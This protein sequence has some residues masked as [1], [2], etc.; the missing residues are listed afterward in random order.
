MEKWILCGT[1]VGQHC[2][3]SKTD[4]PPGL[5]CTL[6]CWLWLL[7]E[8]DC[9]DGLNWN[10]SPQ[11]DWPGEI[12]AVLIGWGRVD[13]FSKWTN[14]RQKLS[15]KTKRGR[16]KGQKKKKHT[17]TVWDNREEETEK[18]RNLCQKGE[19]VFDILAS[20]TEATKLDLSVRSP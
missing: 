8:S 2:L 5:S 4:R 1:K 13:I 11:S 17:E 7:R 15:K 14:S 19:K 9:F 20:F 12:L 16:N 10:V 18:K 3:H 6:S